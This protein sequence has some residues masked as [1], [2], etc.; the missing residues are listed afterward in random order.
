MG[1][2]K[3][4][5]QRVTELGT[6]ANMGTEQQ[7]NVPIGE[8]E[9][10]RERRRRRQTQFR[11]FWVLSRKFGGRHRPLLFFVFFFFSFFPPHGF[12]M[13][14]VLF[15]AQSVCVCVCVFFL[16][17]TVLRVCYFSITFSS[18]FVLL[19]IACVLAERGEADCNIILHKYSSG[20]HREGERER[21]CVLK[22]SSEKTK[23]KTKE[24]FVCL[25]V[26]C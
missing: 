21:A 11:E 15:A 17:R 3:G 23:K 2:T 20:R 24:I 7:G 14:C 13:V 12:R 10:E 18:M 6:F 9:R 5:S 1:T 25:F 22:G 8:R 4:T 26:N 19:Q 16:E